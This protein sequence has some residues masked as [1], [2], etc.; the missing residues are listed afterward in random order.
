MNIVLQII[1]F[2]CKNQEI[3]LRLV[4]WSYSFLLRIINHTYLISQEIEL[5]I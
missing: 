5:K 2:L 4:T 1:L 3:F